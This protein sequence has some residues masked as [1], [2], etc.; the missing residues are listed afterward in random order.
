ME[1][2]VKVVKRMSRKKVNI[3]NLIMCAQCKGLAVKHPV[4][5]IQ[6]LDIENPDGI[7]LISDNNEWVARAICYNCW[8]HPKLKGHFHFNDE[9]LKFKLNKAGSASLG[10]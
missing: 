8:Q 2:S 10:G 7:L 5:I 3:E 4:A 1:K 9:A 6:K